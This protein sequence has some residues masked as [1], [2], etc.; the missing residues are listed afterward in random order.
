[1][2][3]I[4]INGLGRIGRATL[5]IVL[6]TPGLELVAINDLVPPDNLAY[7]L[8]FDTVY[9]RYN[10]SVKAEEAALVIDDQRYPVFSEKDPSQLPWRDMAVDIVLE[11]TGVF[12]Q[13]EGLEKHLQAGARRVMLSAPAKSDGIETIV[14]GVNQPAE[15]CDM[16]STA[17]C[18]TNCITPVAE[19]MGRRVGVKKAIMTTVHAYTSSQAIVDGPSSKYRRGRAAAANFVPTSTGAAI[20]TTKVLPQFSGKFD[21]VAI[22]GPIPVGS[23]CDMVFVTDRPTRVDEINDIFRSEA[24]T[25]QYRGILGC[26]EQPLVSSDIIQDPRASIV[27]LTMTQVVDGD[28]VKIMAWYDNEWG[29]ASQMVKEAVRVSRQQPVTV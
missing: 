22:R 17:S 7:L 20:A 16:F 3:R 11:C 13:R 21:G 19:V 9:G 12:R 29:Y 1:M 15:D 2:A 23:I 4:A 10:R 25:D 28:L 14:H 5:K 24:D 6:D 18:T 27:D 8:R 26:T